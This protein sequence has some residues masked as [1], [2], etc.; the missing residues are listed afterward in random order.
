M[1]NVVSQVVYTALSKNAETVAT[2]CGL[3]EPE[4]DNP[5]RVT[6]GVKDVWLRTLSFAANPVGDTSVGVVATSAAD[7]WKIIVQE[8]CDAPVGEPMVEPGTRTPFLKMEN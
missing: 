2:I 3:T 1:H 4:P 6:S 7:T 8:F 5:F